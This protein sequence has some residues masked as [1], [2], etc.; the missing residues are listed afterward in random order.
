MNN[1]GIEE[2]NRVR[3][4]P[5]NIAA[6]IRAMG[7]NFN[8]DIMEATRDLYVRLHQG[9]SREGVT[10]AKNQAYGTDPR[11]LLDIHIPVERPDVA[12]GMASVIYIHGG[13]FVAGEKNPAG[14]LMYGNIADYFARHGVIGINAQYRLAPQAA[15][16]EGARDVGAVLAWARAHI[17]GFGGNPERVFLM[18]QSAG[19]THVATYVFRNRVHPASGPGV[20][21]AILLSGAYAVDANPAPNTAAYYGSD[22]TAYAGRQVLGNVERSDFPVYVG[23]AEYDPVRFEHSALELMAE[24]FRRTGHAPRFKQYLG[25]NHVSP[26]YSFG[27]DDWTVA[28][29]VLDFVRAADGANK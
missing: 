26:A 24:L 23:L 3:G 27:T 18:G 19:A 28:A 29:D 11:Q 1:I 21:G 20:A 9:R 10:V 12:G 7:K 16:P 6:R 17:A 5:G 14:E 15:W 8:H 22:A 4:V 13:G 25:H 2:A